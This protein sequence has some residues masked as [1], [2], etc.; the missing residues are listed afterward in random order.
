[1][2][3]AVF[4][5]P[6]W[7][8]RSRD[9]KLGLIHLCDWPSWRG[10]NHSGKHPLNSMWPSNAIRRYRSG[11]I[12]PE[13]ILTCHHYDPLTFIWGQLF[14]H[15]IPQP[16]ITVICLKNHLSKILF[17]SSSGQYVNIMLENRALIGLLLPVSTNFSQMVA[18]YSEGCWSIWAYN[19]HTLE[20]HWAHKSHNA[21]VPYFH[22]TAL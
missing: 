10:T 3:S 20:I 18:L 11:L 19:F 14:S 5:R 22:N 8:S 17:K 13:P 15:G 1:M 7:F 12:L 21:P 2:G 4:S 6:C 9:Y 16:Q